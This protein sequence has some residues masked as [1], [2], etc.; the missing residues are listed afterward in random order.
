MWK[1]NA[2]RELVV[3]DDIHRVHAVFVS[4]Y[5]DQVLRP[6]YHEFMIV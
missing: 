1:I 5:R 2:H 4:C 6:F 3:R